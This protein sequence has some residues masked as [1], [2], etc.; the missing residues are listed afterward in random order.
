MKY[1]ICSWDTELNGI[2]SCNLTIM[3]KNRLERINPDSL[4]DTGS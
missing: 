4:K 2:A 1:K 3:Y